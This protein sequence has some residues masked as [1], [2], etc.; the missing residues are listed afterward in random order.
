MTSPLL[1]A[2]GPAARG[3]PGDRTVAMP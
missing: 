3:S 1:R 2:L